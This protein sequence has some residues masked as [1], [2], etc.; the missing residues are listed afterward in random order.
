MKVGNCIPLG[1]SFSLCFCLYV[2]CTHMYSKFTAE[3]LHS[4]PVDC[5]TWIHSLSNF[6]SFFLLLFLRLLDLLSC[7]LWVLT[8]EVNRCFYPG[9]FTPIPILWQVTAEVAAVCPFAEDG[10]S[11]DVAR[12]DISIMQQQGDP[13]SPGLSDSSFVRCDHCH[14]FFP[15]SNNIFL[16]CLCVLCPGGS[17]VKR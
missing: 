4:L 12:D 17:W 1:I 14:L 15:P 8:R 7:L 3:V 6:M 2:R 11:V 16:L 10:C 9:Y 5:W 13:G